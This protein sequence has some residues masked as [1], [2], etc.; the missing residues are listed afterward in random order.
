MTATRGPAGARIPTSA[1]NMA[2]AGSQLSAELGQ[3]RARRVSPKLLAELRCLL[4]AYD[5]GTIEF[6]QF[7]CDRRP[8]HGRA[9]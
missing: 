8:H 9:G 4:E 6:P 3:R 5:A 7:A 1:Q 2:K